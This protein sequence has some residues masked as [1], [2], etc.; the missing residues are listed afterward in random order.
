MCVILYICMYDSMTIYAFR[1]KST[2][3]SW[4]NHRTKWAIFHGYVKSPEATVCNYAIWCKPP[5]YCNLNGEPGE[6]G[7]ND[8]E[9]RWQ[10]GH[11]AGADCFNE[12]FTLW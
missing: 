4:V 7:E 11:H 1:K 5:I 3:S 2:S 6:P 9:L 10:N 8:D 12:W